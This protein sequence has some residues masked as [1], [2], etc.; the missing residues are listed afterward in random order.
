MDLQIKSEV[1]VALESQWKAARDASDLPKLLGLLHVMAAA[2]LGGHAC[3]SLTHHVKESVAAHIDGIASA[4]EGAPI[5]E[6]RSAGLWSNTE[7]M[8]TCPSQCKAVHPR[9]R[10]PFS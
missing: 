3:S 2:G 5:S 4:G 7:F 8:D 10:P 6:T 9:T 1:T